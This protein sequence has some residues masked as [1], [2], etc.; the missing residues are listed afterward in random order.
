LTLQNGLIHKGAAY[1]WTDTAIWDAETSER[2][3]DASKAFY[4]TQ[5]PWAAVISGTF[6]TADFHRVQRTISEKW[7]LNP[8]ELMRVSLD[9]IRFE[10][11]MG[12][13]C[14]LLITFPCEQYGA[15]MFMLSSD[16][17]PFTPAFQPYETIEYMSS[18][19]GSAWGRKLVAKEMTPK[20]ML[21]FIDKQIRHP[22]ET[23]LGWKGASFL[24]GNLIELKV[25]NQ[26]VESRVVREIDGAALSLNADSIVKAD[27]L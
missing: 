5:W 9:A 19:N 14:R 6:D 3:G 15:R 7:P 24:G 8:A 17:L 20:R 23:V 1:L 16:D 26:R 4:G 22:T 25:A 10:A 18:G 12:R 11:S 13:V 27:G 21:R 2:I